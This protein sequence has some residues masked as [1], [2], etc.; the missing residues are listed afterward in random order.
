MTAK[1]VF[2]S[3]SSKDNEVALKIASVLSN[4]N[5]TYW[6]DLNDIPADGG[7]FAGHITQGLEQAKIFLLIL[8]SSAN[9][10]PHV[11]NEINMAF[12]MRLPF[13]IY[14]LDLNEADFND[15]LRYYLA[16]K[17]F[18]KVFE[19]GEQKSLQML[20]SYIKDRQKNGGSILSDKNIPANKGN[21]EGSSLRLKIFTA[22]LCAFSAGSLIH[23]YA[24]DLIKFSN[25]KNINFQVGDIIEFGSY[26]NK[27]ILWV[28][29]GSDQ[30]TG[31][32][33]FI[34]RNLLTAK[35]FDI[36]HSGQF[37]VDRSGLKDTPSKSMK[38][39]D[40]IKQ[41]T[42]EEFTDMYG[43]ADYENSSLR[44]WLNSSD[45][46]VKYVYTKP[47]AKSIKN[48]GKNKYLVSQNLDN[49]DEGGFLTGF[50]QEE[51]SMLK[52][53]TV[54]YLVTANNVHKAQ[55]R[56]DSSAVLWKSIKLFPD[57]DTVTE[58]NMTL[59]LRMYKAVNFR[60][61]YYNEVKER[62][63]LPSIEEIS[64][65]YSSRNLNLQSQYDYARASDDDSQADNGWWTRTPCGMLAYTVCMVHSSPNYS[66]IS[67]MQVTPQT[68]SS[69]AT[70]R[71]V[72][73]L[74]TEEIECIGDGSKASP[75]KCRKK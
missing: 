37:S 19:L 49:L 22:I 69:L 2:I 8:S 53:V 36:A 63:S 39:A 27:P 32:P 42:P 59:M 4:N 68:V 74:R 65:I 46:N 35:P 17:Q 58:N 31:E 34:S 11:L 47:V 1:D 24:P 57:A 13:L 33:S 75:Y 40:R 18:I 44:I 14:N 66:S 10:S 20:L 23:T 38:I 5:I 70:V 51:I 6:L 16:S 3:H 48:A 7:I 67:D 45:N 43:S 25:Y 21:S 52:P 62:V 55:N 71:P 41:F 12:S 60:N 64:H 50:S 9:A 28:Y 15:D 72:I 29:A 26:H 73:R 54:R 30:P 56:N 61:F